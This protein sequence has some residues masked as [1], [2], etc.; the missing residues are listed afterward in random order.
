MSQEPFGDMA[1]SASDRRAREANLARRSRSLAVRRA[2]VL[3]GVALAVAAGTA[4]GMAIDHLPMTGF[5]M[6]LVGALAG[7]T[8]GAMGGLLLAAKS[9]LSQES[10]VG[11]G[12]ARSDEGMILAWALTGVVLGGAG[13]SGLFAVNEPGRG[14]NSP[15]WFGLGFGTVSAVVAGVYLLRSGRRQ[16]GKVVDGSFQTGRLNDPE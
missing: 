14:F 16:S 5:P 4:V 12:P 2:A 9:I 3:V 6:R 1:E 7:S 8:F 13:G 10:G 11:A 15:L